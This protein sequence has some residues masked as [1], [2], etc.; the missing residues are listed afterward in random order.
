M[1]DDKK[2]A[3]SIEL[4]F[5]FFKLGMFTFGGGY[6]MIVLI[7][8][9]VVTNRKWVEE[10][11]ILDVLALSQSMPGAIA[12]NAATIIGYKL[13]GLKGAIISTVGTILPSI[14]TISIIA[15]FL[16]GF[17]DY[18]IVQAAFIGIRAGIVALVLKSGIKIAKAAIADRITLLICCLTIIS[19]AFL[20][21][22]PIGMII[23]SAL[24]GILIYKI[25]P[26]KAKEILERGKVN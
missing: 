19:V 15:Q 18:E 23:I 20:E 22:N 1:S 26:Q 7:E 11:D 2:T 3:K 13:A 24:I 12:I 8:K 10:K 9:E 21:I 16:V 5:I 17:L 25:Y 4:F 6:A 14:I